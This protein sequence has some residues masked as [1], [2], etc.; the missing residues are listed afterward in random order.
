MTP[1]N[2]GWKP[3]TSQNGLQGVTDYVLL[4]VY[5]LS[6]GP[7]HAYPAAAATRHHELQ[8]PHRNTRIGG[9]KRK[10]ACPV[11]GIRDSGTNAI[12]MLYDGQQPLLRMWAL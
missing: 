11:I 3:K 6:Y 12:R 4:G 5:Q 8:N 7:A 10:L 9:H 2:V 1:A